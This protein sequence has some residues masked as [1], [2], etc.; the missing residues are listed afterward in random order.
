MMPC[1]ML[2]RQSLTACAV[3]GAIVCGFVT[4]LGCGAAAP[5]APTEPPLLAIFFTS[6]ISAPTLLIGPGDRGQMVALAGA[7][8]TAIAEDV[9]A[10]ARWE[11]TNPGVASIA[12][13][14]GT[15][16]AISPGEADIRAFYRGATA[17]AHVTVFPP[18]SVRQLQI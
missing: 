9:T 12:A 15:I 14:G 13:V 1:A 5:T 11:S 2:S 17:Q 8:P 3:R 10:A 4:S 7:N 18:E 16:T 6:N